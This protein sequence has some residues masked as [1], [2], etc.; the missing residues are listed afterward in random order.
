MPTRTALYIRCVSGLLLVTTLVLWVRSEWIDDAFTHEAYFTQPSVGG[1]W[2]EINSSNG[3]V[4]VSCRQF[5]SFA[6]TQ[7]VQSTGTPWRHLTGPPQYELGGWP[8][9]RHEHTTTF[10]P[11][12]VYLLICPYWLLALMLAVPLLWY[13][14]W[15]GYGRIQRNRPGFE[16]VTKAAGG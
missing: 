16:V 11:A 13:L 15:R 10:L 1:R 8:E 2:W 12:D 9:W 5:R 7:S 4:R 3:G 14:V 6:T